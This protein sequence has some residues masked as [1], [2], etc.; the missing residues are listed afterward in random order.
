MSKAAAAERLVKIGNSIFASIPSSVFVLDISLTLV[1]ALSDSAISN[2]KSVLKPG[3][4]FLGLSR[5][6]L[7][8]SLERIMVSP[9]RFFVCST[10]SEKFLTNLIKGILFFNDS[11]PIDVLSTFS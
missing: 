10:A 5:L 7:K 9:P 3:S 8:P 1:N 4:G 2:S 11:T 6:K